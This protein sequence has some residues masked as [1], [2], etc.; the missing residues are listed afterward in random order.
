MANRYN[1]G[2]SDNRPWGSWLVIDSGPRHCTKRIA[3][4]PGGKLSLQLHHQRDEHWIVVEGV[5]QVTLDDETFDLREND[6]IFIPRGMKHR[7]VNQTDDPVVVIETQVGSVL[8]EN[9]IIRLQD[10]YNRL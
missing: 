9:D 3:V 8:D 4:N 5:A 6:S 1:T 2:D 7:L 10:D